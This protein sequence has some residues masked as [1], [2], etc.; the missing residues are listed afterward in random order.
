VIGFA[1]T[2]GEISSSGRDRDG[3]ARLVPALI[4]NSTLGNA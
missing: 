3:C 2:A 1:P 4:S